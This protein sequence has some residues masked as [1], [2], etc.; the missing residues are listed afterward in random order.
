WEGDDHLFN[1]EA[2]VK[3]ISAVDYRAR[4]LK[5]GLPDNF[6]H[7]SMKEYDDWGNEM[8]ECDEDPKPMLIRLTPTG[9]RD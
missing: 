7:K 9:A 8:A 3:S 6:D 1:T 5:I 4:G 2:F